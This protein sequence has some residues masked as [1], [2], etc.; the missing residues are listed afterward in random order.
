MTMETQCTHGDELGMITAACSML[1]TLES[2]AKHTNV[3]TWN[4][5]RDASAN[6]DEIQELLTQVVQ[7]SPQTQGSSPTT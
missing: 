2:P 4:D 6:D 1:P 5:V 3:V 7:D